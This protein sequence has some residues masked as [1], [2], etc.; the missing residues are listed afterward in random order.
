MNT[1]SYILKER[2][3]RRIASFLC[4]NFLFMF[5]EFAYGFWTNS[6]GLI[7]D[8]VHMMFDCG[9]LA[10]GLYGAYMSSW[11]PNK[12]YSYG[13]GRYGVLCGFTNSIFLILVAVCIVI[14]A[15]ERVLDPPK[16]ESE[17]LFLVSFA[18]F[19]VNVVGII[20]FRV[21]HLHGPHVG[22]VFL[23]I[24]ADTLGSV[25]VMVSSVAMRYDGMYLADPVCSIMIGILIFVSVLPLV[26]ETSSILL[27][28]TPADLLPHLPLV[29]KKI[30]GIHGVAAIHQ[31]HTWKLASNTVIGTAHLLVESD[32]HE[33]MILHEV[34]KTLKTYGVAQCTIQ[35]RKSVA[36]EGP[37]SDVSYR[38][39][40]DR[41]WL[42]TLDEGA[43]NG[44]FC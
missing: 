34:T 9:A 5:V 17:N 31:L 22:A 36:E 30:R 33:Q 6:L 29:E 25:S 16:V 19:L 43:V 15:I 24:L 39:R 11:R 7:S 1:I 35:V 37:S 27:Q 20:V 3:A 41:Q 44:C 21:L 40:N 23:H 28:Q 8:A 10:L 14:E 26:K 42:R 2:S 18:G 4:I 12:V 32:G 38:F 13:Y